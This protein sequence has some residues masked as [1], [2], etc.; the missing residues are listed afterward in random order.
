VIPFTEAIIYAYPHLQRRARIICATEN[1][2]QDLVHDVIAHA[3]EVWGAFAAKIDGT[4]NQLGQATAWLTMSLNNR[5]ISN[6][7]RTK[8]RADYLARI[9]C[10]NSGGSRRYH[11]SSDQNWG[12]EL[13]TSVVQPAVSS[14]SSAL[15]RA[16]AKLPTITRQVVELRATSQTRRE[17]AKTLGLNANEVR[18]RLRSGVKAVREELA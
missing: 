4:P 3:I 18:L 14:V 8:V 15:Y 10:E 17:I 2:A 5:Q 6:Y 12:S 13:P 9:R 11:A 1:D 16:L 7:R